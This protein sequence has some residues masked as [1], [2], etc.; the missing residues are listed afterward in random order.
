M[1][2]VE[3]GSDAEEDEER[4]AITREQQPRRVD[5]C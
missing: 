1:S 2:G 4:V 3:A 5:G